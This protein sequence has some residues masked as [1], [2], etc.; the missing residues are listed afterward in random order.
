MA[1]DWDAFENT[2]DLS[3]FEQEPTEVEEE[4][5]VAEPIPF[6]SNRGLLG[7]VTSGVARAGLGLTEMAAEGLEWAGISNP[8][9]EWVDELRKSNDIF[10]PDEDEY[11]SEGIFAG[12]SPGSFTE[13]LTT[14]LG[15]AAPGAAVGAA[16]GSAFT[17]VGTLVGGTIGGLAST[18]LAFGGGSAQQRKEELLAKG[19]SEEEADEGGWKAFL[20]EG[21]IEGVASGVDIFTAGSGRLATQIAKQGLKATARNLTKMSGKEAVKKMA[22]IQ[23]T[24][25]L[26]EQLQSELGRQEEL[27]YGLATEGLGLEDRVENFI[28]TSAM[29]MVFFGAGQAYT[30]KQKSALRKQ[31]ESGNPVSSAIGAEKVRK[32]LVASGDVDLAE[33]WKSYTD[34]KIRS[35]EPIKLD[36]TFEDV[37]DKVSGVGIETR[38]I[39]SSDPVIAKNAQDAILAEAG[40]SG[41][42]SLNIDKS[43]E[44]EE[45][46]QARD[47]KEY[48][49]AAVSSSSV[50]K[51][52]EQM[53]QE[54]EKRRA[55]EQL[56]ESLATP[57]EDPI[58]VLER[59]MYVQQLR[60]Q[61]AAMGEDKGKM[62]QGIVDRATIKPEM[63]IA[64]ESAAV[65]EEAGPSQ[66]EKRAED[67]EAVE[68]DLT[69][70]AI[71]QEMVEEDVKEFAKASDKYVKDKNNKKT[72]E[73]YFSSKD[74]NK[75]RKM[76]TLMKELD[77]DTNN[78]LQVT[79]EEVVEELKKIS[80]GTESTEGTSLIEG[81]TIVSPKKDGPELATTMTPEMELMNKEA[82]EA[83]EIVEGEATD[84][85]ALEEAAAKDKG[86]QAL[87]S[88]NWNVVKDYLSTKKASAREGALVELIQKL[89]PEIRKNNISYLATTLQKAKAIAMP[90]K[91][92]EIAGATKYDAI[93]W[94]KGESNQQVGYHKETGATVEISK[95][96]DGMWDVIVDGD[97]KE[98]I[99]NKTEARQ[100]VESY[101]DP[102][103]KEALEAADKRGTY[104][105]EDSSIDT[106]EI[107]KELGTKRKSVDQT[108]EKKN[109]E[110]APKTNTL[111]AAEK[112]RLMEQYSGGVVKKKSAAQIQADKDIEAMRR[113]E[114]NKIAPTLDRQEDLT[115]MKE[116]QVEE[117]AF[118]REDIAEAF[119]SLTPATVEDRQGN[120]SE[121][122]DA[123]ALLE[124]S[125]VNQP[126][127]DKWIA[128][129]TRAILR[130][131]GDKLKNIPVYN[132][133]NG[134]FYREGKIFLDNK[135]AAV[136]LHEAIHSITI[137]EMNNDSK[138]KLDVQD[139]F[140]QMR[141]EMLTDEQATKLSTMKTS[142]E[143]RE[144]W[145]SH[146]ELQGENV[147]IL[148]A[149]LNKEEFLAQAFNSPQFR[150]RLNN[151]ELK[152]KR[153]R[154]QTAW[155]MLKD[156]IVQALRKA[157]LPPSLLKKGSALEKVFQ[158]VDDLQGVEV[159]ST[160]MNPGTYGAP[161]TKEE[162][163]KR[164][165]EGRDKY[166]GKDKEKV[167]K[168]DWLKDMWEK[169]QTQISKTVQ[170]TQEA[171]NNISPQ[172]GIKL[173]RMEMNI[174]AKTNERAQEA[175]PFLDKYKELSKQDKQDLTLYLSN[176]G[177]IYEE[178]RDALLKE[179]GMT[180]EYA[181]V[182]GIFDEVFAEAE[183]LGL[184]SFTQLESYF[185]RY[186]KDMDGLVKELRKQGEWGQVQEAIEVARNKADKNGEPFGTNDEAQVITD[187]INT[188]RIP[189]AVARKP[190]AMKKRTIDTLS[191]SMIQ[192][193]SES[194]EALGKYI[195][196]MTEKIEV[197]KMLGQTNRRSEIK[198]IKSLA[199]KIDE[200][201]TDKQREKLINQME[202]LQEKLPNYNEAIEEGLGNIIGQEIKDGKI[203]E[204]QEK[205][206]KELLR[207]RITQTGTGRAV[208]ILRTGALLGSLTQM[209]TGIRQISDNA[210][211][212]YQY[213]GMNTLRAAVK[214][215]TGKGDIK[216][217]PFD[218]QSSIKEFSQQP[219]IVDKALQASGLQYLDAFSKKVNL[220][221]A[222]EA[223]R[224]P[225]NEK[226]FMEKWEPILGDNT[227]Q[228]LKDLREGNTT[229]DTKY[230][231]FSSITDF[232]PA[233]LS[234]MP[235]RYLTAGNGRIGY[236]LKSYSIKSANNFYREGIKKIREGDTKGGIKNLVHLG[237]IFALANAS[238][239]WIIDW[240]NGREPDF[241]DSM[242][243]SMLTLAMTSRYTLDKGARE[244]Y[245][246]ATLGNMMVP[247]QLVDLPLTDLI[248]L[249]SGEPTY[250]SLKLLPAVGS[251]TYNN[252]TPQGKRKVM[253]QTRAKILERIE[254]GDID[255][256]SI[257]EYNKDV[258]EINREILK[259]NRGKKESEKEKMISTISAKSIRNAKKKGK[260]SEGD[261]ILD[262]IGSLL[263]LPE[264]HA[265]M[266]P[267]GVENYLS[268]D[269]MENKTDVV[270][271]VYESLERKEGTSGDTTGA[272]KT[273]DIGVTQSA[274][275]TVKDKYGYSGKDYKKVAKLFLKNQYEEISTLPN[276]ESAPL[277]VQE[278]LLDLAYNSGTAMK[279]WKGLNKAMEEGDWVEV[280]KETLDTANS[281]G[282]S[283]KG[284][285]KRRAEAYNRIAEVPIKSIEQLSDGTLIYNDEDGNEI[286][287]YKAKNGRHSKSSTGVLSLWA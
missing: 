270:N 97:I 200:A 10:K 61:A 50:S 268:P 8:V 21:G 287:K 276:F 152:N 233:S 134:S 86:T 141:K 120:L 210:W 163:I 285:A 227:E 265:S 165:D 3:M 168:V 80:E 187:I 67:I 5:A 222:I 114:D 274:I 239:D 164:L 74:A 254:G 77:Q 221:A 151:I 133:N 186:V 204:K 69:E 213:G 198:K 208:S 111:T 169:T 79:E 253:T 201:T 206:L 220:Q 66:L 20:I 192:Y 179:K 203:N 85:K 93:S 236:L 158:L 38:D 191:P 182:K 272:A 225:K 122:K 153:G 240:L 72:I 189:S 250:G 231:L 139:F 262:S 156:F 36:D 11:N 154:V 57:A 147:D 130:R 15:A 89:P 60:D 82:I 127:S 148:Y 81:E 183:E 62:A 223:A 173:K 279:G 282:K 108:E 63:K 146:P 26:T 261:S 46:K 181:K 234:E 126:V 99:K 64:E 32:D 281:G 175:K 136:R 176:K 128:P 24:E 232:Q 87:L 269:L 248:N 177:E 75:K 102:L 241:S 40:I 251:M 159:D 185:P 48:K 194:P 195:V 229:E 247:V 255:R 271:N 145:A 135:S 160:D 70:S 35:K 14:S 212:A 245:L 104:G 238:T 73:D 42:G 88:G 49:K 230:V 252:L 65:F 188:G 101:V 171:V 43:Y 83:G 150:E 96:P 142:K 92:N 103:S 259:S 264:A 172:A 54:Q 68:E 207:A 78:V 205:R 283:L 9:D 216:E 107:Y 258:R 143:F 28:T 224:D 235:E 18:L 31:L 184:N 209:T 161:L 266:L 27:K 242:V 34:S 125:L 286:F 260:D 178:R 29:S 23:G 267:Y 263:S 95:N 94:T 246:E 170:S 275:D 110:E 71:E 55:D 129:L 166:F 59:G 6:A 137:E 2:Y 174:N 277:S 167:N 193:Y 33:Q 91:V 56:K 217:N 44:F 19:F 243:D 199:K 244:G 25:N 119:E 53:T 155:S 52:Q 17:P 45:A 249:L 106:E 105:K 112:A 22:I 180:E 100:A 4:K 124:H 190:G 117:G 226:K 123:K 39:V 1:F 121:I 84:P 76:F 7:D 284:L 115:Q 30:A 215:G 228:T 98:S 144:Q 202:V 132:S 37:A 197:A 109:K 131:A 257:R 140:F 90:R 157:G 237:T 196:E 211:T 41:D 278:E 16:I 219:K 51:I 12:L 149:F 47:S 118:E 113:E 256:E 58:D 280:M 162:K 214:I 116:D 138:L 273:Y 13:S 218:F